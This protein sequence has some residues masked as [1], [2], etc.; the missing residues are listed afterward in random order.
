MYNAKPIIT[1][2][3]IFVI[4][5]TFPFWWNLGK[6]SK[7]PDPLL[8]QDTTACVEDTVYMRT[9]HMILLDSWRD[10][11]V[12]NGNRTYESPTGTYNI[13]LT[14]TCLDCHTSKADFCDKCHNYASVTPYCW[15]CHVTAKGN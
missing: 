11:V 3:V 7:A 14:N 5:A 9:S 12:R 1:G 8:P 10:Q 2:L 13:S 4:L 6:A 15:E